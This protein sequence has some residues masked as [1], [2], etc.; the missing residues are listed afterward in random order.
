[1]KKILFFT[2]FILLSFS[3]FAQYSAM[4]VRGGLTVGIQ[5]WSGTQRQPMFSY[6]ADFAYEKFNSDKFSYLINVGYHSRG[7]AYRFNNINPQT[8]D[9]INIVQRDVFD[10]IVSINCIRYGLSNFL[11]SYDFV[12]HIKRQISGIEP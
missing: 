5:N 7:S 10:N 2:A 1:M 4:G 8:G 12:F 6:H 3:S 9:R 11:V